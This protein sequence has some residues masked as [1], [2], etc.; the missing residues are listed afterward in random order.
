MVITN[1]KYRKVS[2][3]FTEH[4]HKPSEATYDKNNLYVTLAR[5]YTTDHKYTKYLAYT[6]VIWKILQG[7]S[8]MAIKI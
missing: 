1:Y 5:P 7:C 3:N 2:Y 8:P 6:R 4:Q